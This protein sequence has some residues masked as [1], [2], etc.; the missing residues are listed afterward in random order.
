VSSVPV[1]FFIAAAAAERPD[2]AGFRTVDVSCWDHCAIT[3]YATQAAI[4]R[5]FGAI[6]APTGPGHRRRCAGW[7]ARWGSAPHSWRRP[8]APP[9][10]LLSA[11][12][13]RNRPEPSSTPC[14]PTPASTSKGPCAPRPSRAH[15]EAVSGRPCRPAGLHAALVRCGGL[16]VVG[17]VDSRAAR[18]QGHRFGRTAVVLQRA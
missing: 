11:A 14:C 8:S 10:R 7:A 1:P 3:I 13:T 5:R 4:L 2:F 16:G 17:L 18:Q 12:I 15:A 9:A 6:L